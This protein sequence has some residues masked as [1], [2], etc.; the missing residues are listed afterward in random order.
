MWEGGEG[1]GERRGGRR[2]NYISVQ[3]HELSKYKHA[4]KCLFTVTHMVHLI[5]S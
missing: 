4:L 5:K 3:Q 2:E 1:R